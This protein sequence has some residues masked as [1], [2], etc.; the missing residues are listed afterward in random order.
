MK[1]LELYA[2]V[3]DDPEA[4]EGIGLMG[5]GD[6]PEEMIPLVS[7]DVTTLRLARPVVEQLMRHLGRTA[8]LVRFTAVEEVECINRQPRQ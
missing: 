7:R 1:A 3:A 8:R 5:M 4:P 6:T 2:W